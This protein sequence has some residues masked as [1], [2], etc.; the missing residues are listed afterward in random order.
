MNTA[1]SHVCSARANSF[2][3][4]DAQGRRCNMRTRLLCAGQVGRYVSMKFSALL[5]L[6][7]SQSTFAG[8]PSGLSEWKFSTCGT[9]EVQERKKCNAYSAEL[10]VLKTEGK[11]CGWIHQS[12]V[13]KSPSAW[14]V[15]KEYGEGALVRYVDSF[16]AN[17][18]DYGR[19]LLTF[20]KGVISW[21]IL[22]E[23]VLGRVSDEKNL[24]RVWQRGTSLTVPSSSCEDLEK[25]S[26]VAIHLS[27]TTIT[28][29]SIESP[30]ALAELRR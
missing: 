25:S 13:F 3:D 12:S 8:L 29:R 1:D 9:Q 22:N 16:Q 15:G 4:P 10:V 2:F 14:F 11:V 19:A 6:L 7:F 28:G 5:I 21:K 26:P 27:Q 20:K 23:P 24:R 17:E 18:Q 30:S